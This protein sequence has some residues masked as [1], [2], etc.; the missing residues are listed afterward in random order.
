MIR[1][2]DKNRI[3][4]LKKTYANEIRELME[5]AF[6]L[7]V[8]KSG[9][10]SGIVSIEGASKIMNTDFDKLIALGMEV[11]EKFGEAMNEGSDSLAA[12]E[13]VTV[14]GEFISILIPG[15]DIAFRKIA[16]SY[17]NH[18]EELDKKIPGLAEFVYEAILHVY[19]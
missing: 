14:F 16:Q 13:A 2:F 8:V 9:I 15:D 10:I 5:S 18:K 12:K 4:T 1:D 7:P 11:S 3:E 17:L 19:Q 6:F